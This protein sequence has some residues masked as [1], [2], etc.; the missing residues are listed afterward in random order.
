MEAKA[1]VKDIAISRERITLKDVLQEGI[2]T[3]LFS[4]YKALFLF[5]CRHQQALERSP[6]KGPP[7]ILRGLL[8][9]FLFRLSFSVGPF[10]D[11]IFDDFMVSLF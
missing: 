11:L 8:F 4:T 10:C 7:D 6:Q 9:A 5:C 1:K 2:F 3:K